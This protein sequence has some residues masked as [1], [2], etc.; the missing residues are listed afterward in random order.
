[1]DDS[2]ENQ[3]KSIFKISYGYLE[4]DIRLGYTYTSCFDHV[5]IVKTR[6]PYLPLIYTM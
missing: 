3:F 6:N 5:S 4:C 1:M 2:K